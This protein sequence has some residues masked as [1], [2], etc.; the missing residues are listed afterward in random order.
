MGSSQASGN[1]ANKA[2]NSGKRVIWGNNDPG[3]RKGQPK[4]PFQTTSR[5]V[6]YLQEP[7]RNLAG[8]VP[9]HVQAV[10]GEPATGG[11]GVGVKVM[12]RVSMVLSPKP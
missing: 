8:I 10:I 11:F 7:G 2:T 4:P 3:K 5:D 1:A 12:V 9:P 6:D